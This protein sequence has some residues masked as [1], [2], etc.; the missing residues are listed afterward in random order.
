MDNKKQLRAG[1]K[2][3]RDNLTHDE[4]I[5]N[6]REIYKNIIKTG[7][8]KKSRLVLLYASINNEPDMYYIHDMIRSQY[9]GIDIGY[10]RVC[11]DREHMDYYIVK[12]Y[13]KEL[14]KGY[15][16][17]MEPDKDASDIIRP[18]KYIH[19]DEQVIVIVPGLVFDKMGN[20]TGYG[21]GYYDRF[22]S[23][24][25]KENK[26]VKLAVCYDF[27]VSSEE[28]C[29]QPHDIAMDY[30]ITEKNAYRISGGKGV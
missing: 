18:E 9:R 14:T 2:Q 6:T 15:M 3:L 27:Q 16:N 22:L 13:N 11:E 17:I 1:M 7:L 20:R 12:D 10:P 5:E 23:V 28:I 30:V 26:V 25:E 4:V 8:L 24:Y 29:H 19:N 21:G